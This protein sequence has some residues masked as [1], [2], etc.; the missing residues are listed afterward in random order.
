MN[1][2]ALIQSCAHTNTKPSAASAFVFVKLRHHRIFTL[3]GSKPAYN[4]DP[5]NPTNTK[6]RSLAAAR[7]PIC[8]PIVCKHKG[9][10][11]VC[12][13]SIGSGHINAIY[14]QLF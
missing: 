4:V 9:A 8:D 3:G 13:Q 1:I 7:D 2:Q 12:L 11:L 6:A 5:E 14:S 10:K